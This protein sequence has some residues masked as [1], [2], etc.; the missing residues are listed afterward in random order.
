MEVGI[1]NFEQGFVFLFT[2]TSMLIIVSALDNRTVERLVLHGLRKPMDMI[3]CRVAMP[4]G[5][6]SPRNCLSD[7]TWQRVMQIHMIN[8]APDRRM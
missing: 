6:P 3:P 5:N 4:D 1:E 8:A 2:F 7:E